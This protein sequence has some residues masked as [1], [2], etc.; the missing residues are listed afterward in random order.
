M[1]RLPCKD[2]LKGTSTTP[3]CGSFYKSE[4]GCRFGE[5]CSYAHRQL[6]ERPSKRS[7]HG[8]A[9]LLDLSDVDDEESTQKHLSKLSDGAFGSDC[10]YYTSE[11]WDQHDESFE[12]D[13]DEV[14]VNDDE[15]VQPLIEK[16]LEALATFSQA[17]R[18]LTDIQTCVTQKVQVERPRGDPDLLDDSLA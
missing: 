8:N 13:E 9:N 18:T 3:F 14:Q 17:N 2:Y 15:E 11:Q 7:R 10:V 12:R 16:E 4:N 1:A 5:K 6:D